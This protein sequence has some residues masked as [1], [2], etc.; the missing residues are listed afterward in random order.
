MKQKHLIRMIALAALAN[1]LLFS[2]AFARDTYVR[3]Y[4]RRDGVEV[5][6]HYRT[7]PN[8]TRNDNYSTR[9]NINPYTG[10]WGNK[11][12]DGEFGYGG[13]GNKKSRR[14]KSY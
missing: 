1:V 10:E 7:T 13:Y 11:P 3:G 6:P 14:H 8:S 5:Q 12:R 9:E 4:T 2:A